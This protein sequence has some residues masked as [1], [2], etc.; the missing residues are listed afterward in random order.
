MK[1]LAELGDT[2]GNVQKEVEITG[3]QNLYLGE[4]TS[5]K[6]EKEEKGE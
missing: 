4:G 5:S 3:W 6:L 1:Q 2:E